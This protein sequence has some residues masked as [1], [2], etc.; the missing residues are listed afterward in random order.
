M[1]ECALWGISNSHVISTLEIGC[2]KCLSALV[3]FTNLLL[4]YVSPQ[5]F[6][7]GKIM[8][9]IHWKKKWG[10]YVA[11]VLYCSPYN[12]HEID[13]PPCDAF[14][15]IVSISFIDKYWALKKKSYILQ[16]HAYWKLFPE[17]A[18]RERKI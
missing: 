14:G 12:K 7:A 3:L 11:Q 9:F 16:I 5:T 10:N 2:Y 6:F 15:S 18:E 17:N 8:D 13:I 1:G 4:W